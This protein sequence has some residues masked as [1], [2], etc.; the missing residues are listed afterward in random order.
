V[1]TW[2]TRDLSRG[3]LGRRH[4]WG[5]PN[6]RDSSQQAQN[7]FLNLE[8]SGIPVSKPIG[9]VDDMGLK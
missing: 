4:V 8:E 2:P 6:T 3:G 9:F 7:A 5:V 1:A